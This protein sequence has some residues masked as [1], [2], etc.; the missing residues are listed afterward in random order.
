[1]VLVDHK[2]TA[3][4]LVSR[5]VYVFKNFFSLLHRA[6]GSVL[7]VIMS[8]FGK[9]HRQAPLNYLALSLFVSSLLLNHLHTCS[10]SLFCAEDLFSICLHLSSLLQTITEGV[11]LGSVTV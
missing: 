7:L 5:L 6:V 4:Y 10:I 3:T 11:M 9:L 1:M 2:T 8:I